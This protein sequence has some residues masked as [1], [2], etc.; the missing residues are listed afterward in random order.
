MDDYPSR[1]A[2]TG[3]SSP[4]GCDL[5]GNPTSQP[6]PPG[7]K[8]KAASQGE[9]PQWR[10]IEAARPSIR[11]RS[12]TNPPLAKKA[13]GTS[14]TISPSLLSV[15]DLTEISSED[16]MDAPLPSAAGDV[17]MFHPH[18]SAEPSTSSESSNV[19]D[20]VFSP[21]KKSRSSSISSRSGSH[22]YCGEE[23]GLGRIWEPTS[24]SDVLDND[25]NFDTLFDQYIR[26]LSPSPSP[27]PKPAP[28][29]PPLNDAVS[30]LSGS[31]IVDGPLDPIRGN[32]D[33][34][35]KQ[36]DSSTIEDIPGRACARDRGD[37]SLVDGTRLRLRV[38]EPKIILRLKLPATTRAGMEKGKGG[39]SR[40]TMVQGTQ[41]GRVKKG[42]KV[43]KT[44]KGTNV[45][46]AKKGTKSEKAKT[47]KKRI[48]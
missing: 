28:S 45:G 38:S 44:K 16:D 19:F 29:S 13:R 9:P 22:T 37:A 33:S 10:F 41:R 23:K 46:Q 34:H 14:S 8:R 36:L 1:T 26:P 48:I 32:A 43:E 31:T 18:N 5:P 21:L 40:D 47:E 20:G 27:A 15:I 39:K 7:R 2:S 17:A 24:P 6:L 4:R 42:T 12:E 35:P 30:N 11:Y 25:S 3:C